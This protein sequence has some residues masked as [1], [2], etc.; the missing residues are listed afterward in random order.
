VD[1]N[2]SGPK[3]MGR[4]C[5]RVITVYL[6]SLSY[7]RMGVLGCYRNRRSQSTK[8][9][10]KSAAQDWG[11]NIRDAKTKKNKNISYIAELANELP[12]HATGASRRRDVGGDG[13]GAEI[14]SFG[15]LFEV[16]S[17]V[18]VLPQK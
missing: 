6:P 10:P 16:T 8:S 12:A 1:S 13:D 18:A 17:S 9:S 11:F 14:A 5:S 2:L 15:S 3:D 7:I 4:S